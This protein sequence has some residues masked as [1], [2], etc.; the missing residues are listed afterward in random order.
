MLVRQGSRTGLR[1]DG[2]GC[3][4]RGRVLD[5][6]FDLRESAARAG[7]MT[8]GRGWR[9]FDWCYFCGRRRRIN[10]ERYLRSAKFEAQVRESFYGG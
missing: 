1:C 2:C 10:V 4:R 6:A 9:R 7:W 5:D 3:E 8:T